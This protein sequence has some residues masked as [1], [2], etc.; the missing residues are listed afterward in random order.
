[1]PKAI[2]QT[3]YQCTFCEKRYDKQ[4][5]AVK[6]ETDHDIV[7]LQ[8][9]RDNIRRLRNILQTSD[10]PLITKELYQ[11]IA[12]AARLRGNTL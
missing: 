5:D 6:C 1:M 8:I 7:F 2:N 9:S 4:R 12:K 11:L 3:I 10:S